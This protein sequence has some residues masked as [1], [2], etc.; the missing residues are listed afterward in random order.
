MA[1]FSGISCITLVV[2]FSRREKRDV[3]LKTVC[4][5]TATF[6]YLTVNFLQFYK[7]FF[8]MS[9]K[10]SVLLMLLLDVSM[11]A[12]VFSWILLGR[13]IIYPESTFRKPGVVVS[14]S[15]V[16][17]LGWLLVYLHF[18]DADYYI[19]TS[20][21]KNLSA[22]LDLLFF[23]GILSYI[24]F[25]LIKQ[26]KSE[27]LYINKIYLA[28]ISAMLLIYMGWFYINDLTLIYVSYG[29][30][31]WDI[32]PYDP[33]ILFYVLMNIATMVYYYKRNGALSL[34][35]KSDGEIQMG[36][37]AVKYDLTKREAEI[38]YLVYMG[39]SNPEISE[40][41][42]ISTFTVKRHLQNIFKKMNIKHRSELI[43]LI[44]SQ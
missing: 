12:L 21:G 17:V 30:E 8:F 44:K 7:E 11:S 13:A 29:A 26:I 10:M 16:Y 3:F 37:A 2:F 20:F 22:F 4:F 27:F 42:Y 25:N 1:F 39:L 24:L 18:T 34:G 40:R 15:V 28:A 6:A 35:E 31:I 32:Y 23:C 43:H 9:P 36:E 14:L 19:S 5:L 41:L 38:I 33:V